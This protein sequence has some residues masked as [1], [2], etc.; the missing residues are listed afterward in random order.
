M[1]R[2]HFI[3]L[4]TLKKR[5]LK[6][7]IPDLSPWVYIIIA[8]IKKSLRIHG[9]SGSICFKNLKKLVTKLFW[10]IILIKVYYINKRQ[11]APTGTIFVFNF[12]RLLT[13]AIQI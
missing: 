2:H 11:T 6:Y 5:T 9:F 12:V 13:K 1:S 10:F 3:H 8:Y 4:F 7:I